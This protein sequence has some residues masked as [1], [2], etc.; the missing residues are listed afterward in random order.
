MNDKETKLSKFKKFIRDN[1]KVILVIEISAFVIF[2]ALSIIGQ[3]YNWHSVLVAVFDSF[4]TASFISAI[5]LIVTWRTK[6]E[7][8]QTLEAISSV[9]EAEN[10]DLADAIKDL[11]VVSNNLQNSLQVYFGH[12][13]L[14]CR[15]S[16]VAVYDNRNLANLSTFFDKAK[17]EIGILMTN[18]ASIANDR[19]VL[20]VLKNKAKSGVKVKVCTMDVST[21]REFINVRAKCLN[22]T[23]DQFVNSIKHSLTEL[24]TEN[25]ELFSGID[26]SDTQEHN[27][28]NSMQIKTYSVPSSLIMFK[29]DDEYIISFILNEKT[30]R[31]VIHFHLRSNGK[32][33]NVNCFKNHFNSVFDS[34]KYVSKAMVDKWQ[35]SDETEC[36]TDLGSANS[37]NS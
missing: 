19:E 28:E 20:D 29:S 15:T 1:K 31:D 33:D 11:N 13:C 6:D 9:T 17:E 2:L 14:F 32:E 24:M 7:Y 27:V 5:T 4:F 30:S 22:R 10:A 3:H 25:S 26:N 8:D 12:N 37:E 34:G 23:A 35:L 21:S 16:L 36:E 18:V